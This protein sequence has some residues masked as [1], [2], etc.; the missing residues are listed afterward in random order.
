MIPSKMESGRR[1]QVRKLKCLKD[2]VGHSYPDVNFD[3][4][5]LKHC[6]NYLFCSWAYPIL[7]SVTSK[8]Q[9]G[10]PSSEMHNF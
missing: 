1:T 9:T 7:H 5:N 8:S 4:H 2:L 6:G 10:Y 3:I